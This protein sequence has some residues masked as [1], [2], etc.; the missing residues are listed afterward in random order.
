MEFVNVDDALKEGEVV[1][2]SIQEK[3][4]DVEVVQKY[5][6]DEDRYVI[7]RPSKLKDIMSLDAE[8]L[9]PILR[10]SESLDL[11]N[12][13]RGIRENAIYNEGVKYGAQSALYFALD[14]FSRLIKENDFLLSSSFNFQP[15]TLFNGRVQP[16]IVRESKNTL[17]REDSTTFR[18]IQQS[19][20]ISEQA[21]VIYTPNSYHQY[22]QITPVK[23][24]LPSPEVMP[25][26]GDERVAWA[27]GVAKGW[28]KGIEQAKN[29]L[30]D[31]IRKMESDYVGMVR[32]H[33]MEKSGVVSKP[34]ASNLNMGVSTDGS[35]I[36]IGE[37]KFKVSIL[38]EF[39]SDVETWKALPRIESFIDY[40]EE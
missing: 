39:N 5:T 33:L 26:N 32:Y 36:N 20:T 24:Q 17:L 29:I 35:H 34:I 12:T 28:S 19:Y 23:P 2:Q 9:Q 37:V 31:K 38:P 22:L 27:E 4:A 14:K 16:P 3:S 40:E 6:F 13:E 25:R 8:E 11:D 18:S 1:E 30:L 7:D 21:K 10:D 15:L